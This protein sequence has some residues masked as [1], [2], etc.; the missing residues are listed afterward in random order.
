MA[1]KAIIMAVVVFFLWNSWGVEGHSIEQARR[2]LKSLFSD[3]CDYVELCVTRMQAAKTGTELLD[4][5][6][7]FTDHM[8]RLAPGALK[9][10]KEHPEVFKEKMTDP[11]M[12]KLQ[13]RSSV[14]FGKLAPVL[15]EKLA[16]LK[17]TFTTEDRQRFTEAGTRIQKVYNFLIVLAGGE[18]SEKKTE[19]GGTSASMRE[20][21]K[22]IFSNICTYGEVCAKRMKLSTTGRE[23]VAVL[24]VY[25]DYMESLSRQ[26]VELY[27]KDP[28]SFN[29]E[30]QSPE[31][32][33]L[34]K[35]AIALF[36]V[37]GPIVTERLQA[38]R[39]TFTEADIQNI[40]SIS[41][42]LSQVTKNYSEIIKK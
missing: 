27:K 7:N 11:E 26:L 10:H 32:S 12:K 14:L 25:T 30:L 5:L 13:E 39:G 16:E 8:D 37:I 23:F 42:R 2:D 28:E 19:T 18:A 41:N 31:V 6:F 21:L 4:A 17:P 9:L 33:T 15:K 22:L 24:G 1:R 35:R 20:K 36:D 3:I 34:L 38:F 29:R 40:S